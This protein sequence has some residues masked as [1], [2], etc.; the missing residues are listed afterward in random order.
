LTSSAK[1]V[2]NSGSNNGQVSRET[3]DTDL[4]GTCLAQCMSNCPDGCTGRLG[5]DEMLAHIGNVG[6]MRAPTSR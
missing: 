3:I 6:D 5:I 1:I 2:T 4:A